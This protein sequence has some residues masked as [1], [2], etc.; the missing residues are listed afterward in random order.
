MSVAAMSGNDSLVLNNNVFSD[1]ADGD[2]LHL[3]FPNKIANAKT[4]KNGNTIFAQNAMGNLGNLSIMLI[5]GS[6]DDQF[7]QQLLNLQQNNFQGTVLMSGQ[8]VKQIGDG[9]GNVI[10]D[11]YVISGGVLEQIPEAKS[12]AEGDTKQ[13]VVEYKLVFALAPRSIT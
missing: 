3:T 10:A 12:N 6:A 7:L 9:Q 5:R 2:Y 4:G 1:F 8:Y 11:T 13:S